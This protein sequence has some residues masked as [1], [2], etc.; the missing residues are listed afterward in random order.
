M[1]NLGV[2]ADPLVIKSLELILPEKL[3]FDCFW[4][5]IFC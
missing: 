3:L 4:L 1:V 2:P 5:N